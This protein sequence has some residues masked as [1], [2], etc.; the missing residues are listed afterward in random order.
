MICEDITEDQIVVDT[1]TVTIN[2]APKPVDFGTNAVLGTDPTTGCTG[3]KFDFPVSKLGGIETVCFELNVT[4]PVGPNPV[5]VKGGTTSENGLSICGP[6]CGEMP[7][8]ETFTYQT[9]TVCVPVV[10]TPSAVAGTTRTM[11]CGDPVVT[12]NERACTSGNTHCYFTISQ[13]VCIEVPVTFGAT[14]AVGEA[15]ITC[16]NVG[17]S[18][19]DCD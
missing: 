12:P 7:P 4:Y 15:R 1:I 19:V 16:E 5:C 18:C 8:C 13:R 9:A 11:C 14:A 3:L 6:S 10:V 2:G 17:P